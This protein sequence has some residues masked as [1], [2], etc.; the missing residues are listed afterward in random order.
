MATRL[1][2]YDIEEEI[3]RGGM[4][5]VYRAREL[6]LDRLVA[7]KLIAGDVSDV[8]VHRAR[9]ERESRLA[10]SI[11]HPHIVTVHAV[12]D[13][14][15]QPFIAMQ[16][17]DGGDLGARIARGPLPVA[18]VVRIG[19]QI[20]GALQAAHDRG[21]LHRDVKPANILLRAG[22]R[23]HALLADFG[24]ARDEGA[25]VQLTHTGGILGTPLYTAPEQI[26]G[27]GA[28]PRSD[29]YALGCVLYTALAGTPPFE[30]GGNDARLRWAHLHGERP[31]VRERRPDVPDSLDAL[32]VRS[33]A[34]EPSDRPTA[35]EL[36]DA[37][38]QMTAQGLTAGAPVLSTRPLPAPD[39]ATVASTPAAPDAQARAA[40]PRRQRWATLGAAG[41]AV[42]TGGIA[43]FVLWGTDPAPVAP[44]TTATQ[45]TVAGSAPSVAVSRDVLSTLEAYR[46]A[47]QLKDAG[48]MRAGMTADVTRLGR[49]RDRSCGTTKGIDDVMADYRYNFEALRG[50]YQLHGLRAEGALS[51]N[52]DGS[53]RTNGVRYAIGDSG[54][55]GPIQFT[56]RDDGSGFR[57]AR[58]VAGC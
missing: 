5:V 36:A 35:G 48:Q 19:G 57:I 25:D 11:S 20:A 31:H 14:D 4:G 33:M 30:A 21:L 22:S 34:V 44:T 3:G 24:I 58:I 41:A 50:A 43:A 54:S 49:R 9:F 32:I 17:V 1:D 18:D 29:V 12:G 39:A 23:Q 55:S 45:T 15:G 46:A 42:L 56:L 6:R 51:L 13:H 2:N 16:W 7:L 27:D 26:A 40:T 37:L 53:V 8:P 52:D 28:G 47:Y 38:E 10:A